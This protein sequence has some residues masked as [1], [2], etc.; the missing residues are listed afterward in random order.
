MNKLSDKDLTLTTSKND[1]SSLNG[2]FMN[3]VAK[4]IK[5]QKKLIGHNSSTP[6]PNH[7]KMKAIKIPTIHI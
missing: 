5:I 1:I 6:S 3:A 7:A 4:N 2:S